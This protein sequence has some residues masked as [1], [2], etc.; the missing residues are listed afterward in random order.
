MYLR[1][2]Q[3]DALIDQH[4]LYLICDE[5]QPDYTLVVNVSDKGLIIERYRAKNAGE[6]FGW[7]YEDY[8][9]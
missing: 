9:D 7:R 4:I 6:I 2:E 8:P 5:L 3:I 1:Q